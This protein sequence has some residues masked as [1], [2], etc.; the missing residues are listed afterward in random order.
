[1]I[2]F[3]F[4]VVE[5]CKGALVKLW[6]VHLVTSYQGDWEMTSLID[7]PSRYNNIKVATAVIVISLSV[8][9]ST[10]SCCFSHL[11]YFMAPMQTLG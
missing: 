5:G 6:A 11:P 9:L 7:R 3:E 10:C 4:I 8:V 2:G 1:M